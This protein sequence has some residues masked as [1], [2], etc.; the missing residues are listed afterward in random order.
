MKL[1]KIIAVVLSTLILTSLMSLSVSAAE[2]ILTAKQAVAQM[3][4]GINLNDLSIDTDI[5]HRENSKSGNYDPY[6][7]TNMTINLWYWNGGYETLTPYQW[8]Y[9]FDTDINKPFTISVK[10]PDYSKR[11]QDWF[12][13][14]FTIGAVYSETDKTV[15]VKLSNTKIVLKDGSEIKLSDLN[16]T[17]QLTDWGEKDSNGKSTCILDLDS[18]KIPK[19]NKKFNGATLKTTI[20]ITEAPRLAESK[21]GSCQQL[22]VNSRLQ[23]CKFG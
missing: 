5:L 8:P 16:K 9:E 20:T 17:Y 7:K 23:F 22:C 13:G 11:A 10:I 12:D 19:E 21:A 3:T 14:L 6:K 1:R 2:K 4:W 18:D 15:K